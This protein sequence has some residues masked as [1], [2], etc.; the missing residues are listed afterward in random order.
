MV[1][2]KANLVIVNPTESQITPIIEQKQVVDFIF[3]KSADR[4]SSNSSSFVID[5]SWTY[6]K[7][8]NKLYDIYHLLYELIWALHAHF[9]PF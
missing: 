4:L 7:S 8:I 3:D 2:E 6:I 1:S 5:F 9:I